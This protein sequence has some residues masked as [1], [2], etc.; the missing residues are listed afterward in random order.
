MIATT[1]G[2]SIEEML[3]DFDETGMM[4]VQENLTFEEELQW[5]INRYSKENASDTP[6]F[7]LAKYLQDCLESYN[8]AVQAREKWFGR[9]VSYV[10]N[11]SDNTITPP[12]PE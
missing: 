9:S 1:N 6:D 2:K 7:I 3:R 5:L 12:I 8:S 10:E 4:Y 11:P